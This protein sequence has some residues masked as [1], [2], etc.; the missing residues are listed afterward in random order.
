M[1]ENNEEKVK[2]VSAIISLILFGI[3]MYYLLF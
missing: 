1:E 3:G 2:V